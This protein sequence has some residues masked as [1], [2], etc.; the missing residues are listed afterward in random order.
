MILEPLRR[1]TFSPAPT[2]PGGRLR[3]LATIEDPAVVEQILTHLARTLLLRSLA[4]MGVTGAFAAFWARVLEKHLK[5]QKW[6]LFFATSFVGLLFASLL[7]APLPYIAASD[8]GR[9]AYAS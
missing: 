9:Q 5:P 7:I 4:A 6:A 2:A 1:L 3:L 8:S